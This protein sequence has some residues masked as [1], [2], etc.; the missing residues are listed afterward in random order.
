MIITVTRHST[1]TARSSSQNRRDLTAPQFPNRE[2]GRMPTHRRI[3]GRDFSALTKTTRKLP[4]SQLNCAPKALTFN[5]TQSGSAIDCLKRLTEPLYT[6]N[7]IREIRQ[8]F[9][10]SAMFQPL[11][12]RRRFPLPF[13]RPYFDPTALETA[14]HWPRT[15]HIRRLN[16]CRTTTKPLS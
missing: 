13:A 8:I 12:L 1:T 11:Q 10:S 2:I 15:R 3:L 6:S 9:P 4:R 7:P 16:S 14:R 5:L